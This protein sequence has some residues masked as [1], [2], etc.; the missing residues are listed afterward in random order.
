MRPWPLRKPRRA[1]GM[2]SL[3]SVAMARQTL[4]MSSLAD[5]T[6]S[7]VSA[8]ALIDQPPSANSRPDSDRISHRRDVVHSH[9]PC[10]PQARCQRGRNRCRR[11]LG[12]G[13][14]GDGTQ[15]SLARRADQNHTSQ[16]GKL[17]EVPQDLQIVLDRLAEADSGVDGD[18]LAGMP[19]D[20]A[21]SSRFARKS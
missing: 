3:A 19:R 11:S 7:S 4:P 17:L 12:Y 16:V 18:S 5:V 14:T 2:R 8:T 15:K 10:S 20:S 1:A 6:Y 21:H 9:D 13:A